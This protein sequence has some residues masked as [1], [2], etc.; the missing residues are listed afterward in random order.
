[1]YGR[2]MNDIPDN[3]NE[4]FVTVP[5]TPPKPLD[6]H[7]LAAL[8]RQI[9]TNMRPLEAVLADHHLTLEDYHKIETIPYFKNALEDAIREWNSPMK[10]SDRVRIKSAMLVEDALPELGA[11][12]LDRN[13]PLRDAV[14]V[15]KWI[16][17]MGDLG[18]QKNAGQNHERVSITINMGGETLHFDKTREVQSLPGGESQTLEIQPLPEGKSQTSE[19]RPNR[20]TPRKLEFLST[21]PEGDSSGSETQLQTEPS[22]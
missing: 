2:P 18:E 17:R 14:E 8:A 3:D 15:G 11:R 16:S 9:A 20:E 22:K 10:T 12:M 7:T 6:V 5:V 13:E 4:P 1:M 21:Q 19:L